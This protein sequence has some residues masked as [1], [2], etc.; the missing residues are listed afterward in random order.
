LQEIVEQLL[1]LESEII[2]AFAITAQDYRGRSISL[3][4]VLRYFYRD[5]YRMAEIIDLVQSKETSHRILDVGIAYGFLDIVLKRKYQRA[6]HGIELP[7]NIPAYC[8]LCQQAGIQVKPGIL[9]ESDWMPDEACYDVVILGEVLEHLRLSPL[10]AL[11]QLYITLKPG[12]YLLLT[13]PN[14]ARLGHIARLVTGKNILELLPD[15]GNR[16]E[17]ITDRVIHIRE[18]TLSEVV[19]L[20][21]RVGFKVEKAYDSWCW[22]RYNTHYLDFE[23]AKLSLRLR[24]M[25]RHVITGLLPMYRSELI[26]MGR[27]P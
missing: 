27:K 15:D 7:D 1:A 17:H 20:L 23:N 6:V 26:V 2:E 4:H 21:D 19:A 16:L 18:Y 12:G 8:S 24:A 14:I 25:L 10:R 13:T 11:K 3:E 22:D 5:L 9:G